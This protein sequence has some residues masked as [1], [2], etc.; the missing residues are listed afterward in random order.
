ML[1]LKE[2]GQINARAEQRQAALRNHAETERHQTTF[3]NMTVLH[4]IEIDIPEYALKIASAIE[5]AGHEAWFVGGY[6]RDAVLGRKANDVDIATDA[7]WEEVKRLCECA[8]MS[9]YET[10]IKHGTL[11]VVADTESAPCEVTTYRVDGTYSDSRHPDKV[12]FT[13]SIKEDLS[14]RD[15]TMNAMAY[16]PE[17]GLLDPF[18]GLDDIETKTIRV[19]G[20]PKKR[21]SEDALRI[22]RACRFSSQ[23]GFRIDSCTYEA[24]MMCKYLLSKVSTERITH[25]LDAF[26][27]GEFVRDALLETVDV[28]SF[29]LPELVPMKGCAQVTKYHMYDVLEHT[30]HTVQYT[31]TDRLER[32][33][34]LGHDMGKPAAAFFTPDGVEHFYGHANLGTKIVRA[35]LDRFAMSNAFKDDVGVLVRYHDTVIEP[36]ARSVR[37]ML[38]KLD[39]RVELFKALLNLKRADAL[40]HSEEGRKH[41]STIDDLESILEDVLASNEAFSLRDL[42]INGN[43]VIALGKKP[44]PEIGRIL[45]LALDAVIDNKV[46]NEKNALIDFCKAEP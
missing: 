35:M 45:S 4:N 40:A 9:T 41:V 27:L 15:F 12:E 20:E 19:V 28:L 25:E 42:A 38:A 44:G 2:D 46:P 16:H 14:R 30:A 22:L 34:A 43:D 39:G 1:T 24:M 13:S 26:L 33:A 36:N 11:T 10:G 3:R 31:S 8:G 37:R 29:V 5:A 23:L 6:I 32:W 18:H 7:H 21:F 17:R